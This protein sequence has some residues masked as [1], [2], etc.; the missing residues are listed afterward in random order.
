MDLY[1]YAWTENPLVNGFIEQSG[2]VTSFFDPAPPNNTEAWYTTATKLNC[3]NASTPIPQ[4]VACM[5]T[6]SVEAILN[7][8]IATG[9]SA[10]LGTF[11]PTVD[12]E[13][14]F[15]DYERRAAAGQYIQKPY[16]IGNNDYEAGLF[17]IIAAGLS[18]TL[19]DRTWALFDLAFFSCPAEVGASSRTHATS[20]YRYRYFGEYPNT[21]LTSNPDSGAWHGAEIPVIWETTQD[22]TFVPPT[23]VEEAVG[24]YLNSAW[25]AF[26]KDPEHA[27]STP[28]FSWPRYNDDNNL[29][30]RLAYENETSASFI[31]PNTYDLPCQT[32]RGILKELPSYTD[33]L[34]VG[35][36]VLAPLNE[37]ANLTEMGGGSEVGY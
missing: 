17:K 4:T 30:I 24:R 23:P 26:A 8:S 36:D 35:E 22:A 20:T 18:L 21:R 6:K 27:L 16:L 10:F 25:A 12:N 11:G 28:P 5:R 29:L 33:L 34:F 31:D 14:V 3:G 32:V 9:V 37:F 1:S 13:T 19:S 7:A 15:A 2:T